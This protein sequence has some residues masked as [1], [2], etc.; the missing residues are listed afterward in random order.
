MFFHVFWL[1]QIIEFMRLITLLVYG[2]C[3]PNFCCPAINYSVWYIHSYIHNCVAS[4][5]DVI[6]QHLIIVDTC[7]HHNHGISVYHIIVLGH[8]RKLPGDS[9]NGSLP[10]THVATNLTLFSRK[11]TTLQN[12]KMSFHLVS[13]T[14]PTW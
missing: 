7:T 8:R 5:H 6:R 11:T 12:I 14:N 13:L 10:C 4:H 2:L 3:A 1:G 9:L